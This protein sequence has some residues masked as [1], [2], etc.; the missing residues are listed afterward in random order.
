MRPLQADEEVATPPSAS[1]AGAWWRW[2]WRRPLPFCCCWILRG[3]SR[4]AEEAKR[5]GG[6]RVCGSWHRLRHQ[7][8]DVGALAG[9][10]DPPGVQLQ[11]V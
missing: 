6:R 2:R 10:L 4:G 11:L 8:G 1:C 9:A 5:R 7:G 3:G